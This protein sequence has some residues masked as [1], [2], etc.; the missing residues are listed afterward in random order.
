MDTALMIA[1]QAPIRHSLL[2]W[3]RLPNLR[4]DCQSVHPGAA[5]TP[6]P[7]LRILPTTSH[8]PQ[9]T[10]FHTRRLPH[11]DRLD[12]PTFLT[13][14]LAG[15]LP[16]GRHFSPEATSGEAFLA[17]D[18]LLDS[19][20][21]G[22]QHLR[23]PA[24]ANMLVEA[25]RY[26]DGPS[27]Q[28]HKYVVMPNHVHLLITPHE[29]LPCLMRSL[30]RFTAREGNRILGFTGRPFWQAESYDRLVR[31]DEE[32]ARIASYIEMNPVRAGLAATPEDFPWSSAWPIANR[33]QINNLPHKTTHV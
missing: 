25:I 11:Y 2:L 3:G 22:P 23:Q 16:M 9:V 1:D 14:R 31:N 13:W 6:V 15:T 5:R 30:K 10:I 26:R 12:H 21:T 7:K 32:F 19:A 20:R 28:L 18:R 27:Y 17:M 4:T 33:P 24:I 8:Y 29:P